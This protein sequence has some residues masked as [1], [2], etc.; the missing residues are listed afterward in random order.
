MIGINRLYSYIA[1]AITALLFQNCSDVAFDSK[2]HMSR[3]PASLLDVSTKIDCQFIGATSLRYRLKDLL[4]INSGDISILADNGTPTSQMRIEKSKADLGEADPSQGLL[5]NLSCGMSKYKISAEIFI[6]ACAVGMDSP[7]S[8]NHL[9]PNGLGDY[10]LIY[11]AFVGRAPTSYERNILLE[12]ASKLPVE[13]R[14]TGV[15]AA[16]AGSLESLIQI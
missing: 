14:A 8:L 13:K 12:L 16:I 5:Q 2:Q 11:L 10:D 15:C 9:F 6:D 7:K 1:I 4:G 3:G